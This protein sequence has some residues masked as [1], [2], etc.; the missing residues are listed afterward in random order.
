MLLTITN[1]TGPKAS[2]LGYLL[3]KHPS[4]VRSVS[5][6]FGRAHV[7]FPEAEEHRCTCAL[8]LDV[9]PVFLVQRH[10]RTRSGG[11]PLQ[12]YINDRSYVASSF[13]SVAIASLFR[14]GLAGV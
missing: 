14:S 1:H 9:D 11:F 13:M 3:E 10:G 7:F 8:L 5:L 2:D 4:R 12:E 6:S